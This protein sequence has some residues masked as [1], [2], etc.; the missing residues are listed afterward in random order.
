[1]LPRDILISIIRLINDSKDFLNVSQVS[2]QFYKV[3]KELELEKMNQFTKNGELPNGNLHG[4]RN[5]T[6]GEDYVVEHLYFVNDKRH[7]KSI[8]WHSATQKASKCYYK[9]GIKDGK[10]KEW[11]DNG[12][13]K[14]QCTYVNGEIHGECK[15]WYKNGKLRMR[16]F[17]VNGWYQGEIEMFDEG[18]ELEPKSIYAEGKTK[19]EDSSR[20]WHILNLCR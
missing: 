2:K 16:Y 6:F 5:Y 7:G 15:Y 17:M 4:E 11:W 10:Y 19:R 20:C 12:I 18:G 9:N 13:L 14:E 1:M 3:C 8:S